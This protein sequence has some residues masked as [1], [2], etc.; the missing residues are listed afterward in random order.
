LLSGRWLRRRLLD[1]RC[2]IWHRGVNNERRLSKGY[3]HLTYDGETWQSYIL[4]EKVHR[5]VCCQ[6]NIIKMKEQATTSPVTKARK[7]VD[8]PVAFFS[9]GLGCRGCRGRPPTPRAAAPP[10]VA[11]ANRGNAKEADSART[12]RRK[13]PR[14]AVLK[15]AVHAGFRGN[16]P[17]GSFGKGYMVPVWGKERVGGWLSGP[18]YSTH[19]AL[20][21]RRFRKLNEKQEG[22]SLGFTNLPRI[23]R[24]TV[25][26]CGKSS[27]GIPRQN[28]RIRKGSSWMNWSKTK[29]E[30]KNLPI[31]RCPHSRGLFSHLRISLVTGLGRLLCDGLGSIPRYASSLQKLW[32]RRQTRVRPPSHTHGSVSTRQDS[33]NLT[34]AMTSGFSRR[35]AKESP[36]A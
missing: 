27:R 24:S 2:F 28:L 20:G 23:E 36:G 25:V 7:G 18:S 30:G 4:H 32:A 8:S 16:S 31:K 6:R 21:S 17:F 3:S 35:P 34:P 22:R 15:S 1:W 33:G 11:G 10:T 12:V 9:P 14:K 26:H 29:N 13:Y 19:R 5:D